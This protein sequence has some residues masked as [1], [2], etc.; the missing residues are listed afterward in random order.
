MLLL[1]RL[2]EPLRRALFRLPIVLRQRLHIHRQG[3]F[4]APRT[5]L[6]RGVVIG[7][8][9]R[10]TGPGGHFDPCEIG[11]FTAISGRVVVRSENH[12]TEFLNLQE[13]A[14]RRIIGGRTV[15]GATGVPVRIGHGAWIGD[16]VVILPGVEIGNGAVVG[17]GAVVTRSVP[18]YAIAVGNP[19]RVVRY[20]YPEEIVELIRPVEWWTWSDE[21]L[22]AN[23][24]LFE[25]DL[26]TV[27]PEDLRLRLAGLAQEP[28][29]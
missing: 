27:D 15:L 18:D 13:F 21:K 10:I 29:R 12:R 25:L 20:R 6:S 1:R 9:A 8:G 16:S 3:A 14:Q 19:A 11:A 22:R 24:D 17:A 7:R 26:S 4:V 5:F 23:R 28:V 2:T